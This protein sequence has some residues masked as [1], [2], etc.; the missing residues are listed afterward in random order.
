MAE[1]REMQRQQ[2]AAIQSVKGRV[3]EERAMKIIS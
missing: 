1:T 2:T 3:N